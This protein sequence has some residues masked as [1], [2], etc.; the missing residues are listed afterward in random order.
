MQVLIA[1]LVLA[2]IVLIL[3]AFAQAAMLRQLRD[4]QAQLSRRPGAAKVQAPLEVRPAARAELSIVLLADENC[5]ICRELAP[6]LVDL[7]ARAPHRLDFVVL[8]A[9]PNDY[10]A[11][12]G[13]GARPRPVVNAEAFHRLDPGWRPALML[14]DRDG[15]VLAAEPVGSAN[16]LRVAVE[17]FAGE[18]LVAAG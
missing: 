2:W 13:D 9:R 18:R 15:A 14:V 11:A 6:S 16:A 17:R 4:L 8:S 1:G 12:G 3:L 5:P 10:L 7:V